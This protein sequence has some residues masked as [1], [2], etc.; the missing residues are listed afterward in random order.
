MS[1][2]L[3]SSMRGFYGFL[4]AALVL[5]TGAAFLVGTVAGPCL[6]LCA[7]DK[8]CASA[9]CPPAQSICVDLGNHSD[10]LAETN[11]VPSAKTAPSVPAPAEAWRTP[12][13]HALRPSAGL[14]AFR[15]DPERLARGPSRPQLS[16]WII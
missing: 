2:R 13:F 14:L 9:C 11:P 1:S 7:Q 12:S 5:L 6:Q 16:I 4:Y 3:S 15:S 8:A 10:F